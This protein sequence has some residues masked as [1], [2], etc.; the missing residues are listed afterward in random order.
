MEDKVSHS[1]RMEAFN[2][3]Q[4]IATMNDYVL[5]WKELTQGFSF[6]GRNVVLIGAKGIWKPKE[7]QRYPISITSV[8]KSEYQDKII[9]D[10]SMHYSYRGTNPMHY[11]NIALREAME[12]KIPLIY[13]HQI[14][15]GKYFVAWPAF[16]I[17][18]EPANLRFLVR[19]ENQS[20][21]TND[22]LRVS[23]PEAEY[24]QKYTTR[25]VL[26]R[27][28]QRSF[29]EAVL[30]AYRNHCTICRLKHREL[31]DA[32]HIIPD[33][34]EGQPIVS[35]GLSLCKIHHAAF[36]QNILGINPDYHVEIRKDILEETDGPMLK[37]GL[38]STHRQKIILPRKEI[39]K[40]NK[41]W[42][43][44]RYQRFKGVG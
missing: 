20:I 15:K 25:N 37:Y 42:L 8:Q 7:I 1:I 9:D 28:H 44:I 19:V 33:N 21:L 12:N 4:Q 40:P 39:M 31:L 18:D 32:A 13:L 29:R 22:S 38:Q 17:H 6:N 27:L 26:V 34:E 5:N 41:E 14:F 35:N 16:I 23:E 11:D 36:D 10:S 2:W 3:L 24:R 30:S 43:D